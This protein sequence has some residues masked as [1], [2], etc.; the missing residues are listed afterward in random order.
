MVIKLFV[1]DK[2]ITVPV[3]SLHPALLFDFNILTDW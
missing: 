2:N 1:K 3:T